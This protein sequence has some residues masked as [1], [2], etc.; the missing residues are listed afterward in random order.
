MQCLKCD[1]IIQ[2]PYS[3]FQ[4]YT[5][6]GW[7]SSDCEKL[8]HTASIQ[9]YLEFK[10]SKKLG[11]TKRNFPSCLQSKKKKQFPLYTTQYINKLPTILIFS[12]APWIDINNSLTF[13]VARTSKKKLKGIIYTNGNHFTVRLIDKNFIIWYHDS[14]TTQSLM[15]IKNNDQLKK[16]KE[17]YKAIMAFYSEY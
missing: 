16:C 7:S 4:D 2:K 13:N 3:Y 12:L 1:F 10:I 11:K 17:E 15:Q 14:Q 6:V 9:Q 5:A 8:K